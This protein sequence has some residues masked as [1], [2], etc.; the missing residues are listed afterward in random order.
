MDP[1]SRMHTKNGTGTH[2]DTIN[3]PAKA[4]LKFRKIYLSG[5][6]QRSN[7]DPRNRQFSHSTVRK[8][9]PVSRMH[10]KIGTVTHLDTMNKPAKAFLKFRKIDL[11]RRG[12]RSNFDPEIVN[13]HTLRSVKWIP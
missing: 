6:G 12:Q 7:F 3:K 4:F 8:M 11:S 13:F 10:P 9:D 1:V 5:R 2:L